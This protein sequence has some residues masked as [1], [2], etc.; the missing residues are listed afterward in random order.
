MIQ[1]LLM[2]WS[3]LLVISF[4]TSY[5]ILDLTR[6]NTLAFFPI[7]MLLMGVFFMLLVNRKF[8]QVRRAEFVLQ[9]GYEKYIFVGTYIIL[10]V[11]NILVIAGLYT[12]FSLTSPILMVSWILPMICYSLYQSMWLCFST[13]IQITLHRESQELS[14]YKIKKITITRVNKRNLQLIVTTK[15]EEYIYK[16]RAVYILRMKDYI[17]TKNSDVILQQ[18]PNLQ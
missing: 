5:I 1:L 13:A 8:Q 9:K 6:L 16:T 11:I 3:C 4:F 12:N 17:L 18:E 14:Y 15:K 2:L 10:Y 7:G